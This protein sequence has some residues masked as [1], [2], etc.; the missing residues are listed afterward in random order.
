MRGSGVITLVQVYYLWPL[1]VTSLGYNYANVNGH[2]R[3]LAATTAFR[4]EPY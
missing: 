1:F 2:Y 3:L 4:N